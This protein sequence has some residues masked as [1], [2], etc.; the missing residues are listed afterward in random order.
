M[1]GKRLKKMLK[2]KFGK[3][4]KAS[5]VLGIRYERLS[6]LANGWEVPSTIEKDKIRKVVT[7]REFEFLNSGREI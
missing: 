7:P 1:N 3:L 6:V 4:R 2:K 5:H